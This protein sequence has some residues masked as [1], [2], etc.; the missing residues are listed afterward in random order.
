MVP[1]RRII[2]TLW[3]KF[4]SMIKSFLRATASALSRVRWKSSSVADP[5]WASDAEIRDLA[6][7]SLQYWRKLSDEAWAAGRLQSSSTD[8]HKLLGR[9]PAYLNSGNSSQFDLEERGR[10]LLYA[11][12]HSL[13]QT[14]YGGCELEE[15]MLYSWLLVGLGQPTR[16]T[17]GSTGFTHWPGTV[18]EPEDPDAANYI[19]I[20]VYAWSYILSVSKN[21]DCNDTR[22]RTTIDV[23][24]VSEAGLRWWAAL[25]AHTH[26][27]QATTAYKRKTYFSPWSVVNESA[28]PYSLKATVNLSTTTN[29]MPPTS[30]E[31]LGHLSRFCMEQ[32]LCSQW[33]AAL[34]ATLTLTLKTLGPKATILPR[35]KP[36]PNASG[37]GRGIPAEQLDLLPYYMS[38]SANST[39]LRASLCGGFYQPGIACNLV[40]AWLD[41]GIDHVLR[42]LLDSGQGGRIAAILGQRQPKT[43]ALWIGAA[44]TGLTSSILSLV[45]SGAYPFELNASAWT[46]CAQTYLTSQMLP[47]ATA[48]RIDRAKEAQLLFLTQAEG[49]HNPP[50]T[51]WPPFLDAL[52]S[53]TEIEV[54]PTA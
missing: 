46:G 28:H 49:C 24:S 15:R 23:G 29:S 3:L 51:P 14:S 11:R 7:R 27:W 44:I 12:G 40:S 17:E 5:V 30:E 31:A 21:R 35:T 42:P 39:G 54:R 26:G 6:S 18:D 36:L 50:I 19:A 41:P 38:I 34:A 9:A 53:D 48:S 20:L 2:D 33:L 10:G 45:K 1:V 16:C 22:Q 32:G 47:L 37:H 4:G 8:L 25:L 43:A 13:W 52:L